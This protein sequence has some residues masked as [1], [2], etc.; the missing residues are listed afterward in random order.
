MTT[1]QPKPGCDLATTNPEL[2]KQA[3]DWDPTTATAVSHK[4]REWICESGHVWIATVVS[5]SQG[6]GCPYDAGK[7]ALAGY[8][9]LATTHPELAKQAHGRDLTTVM[10]KSMAGKKREWIC[11]LGHVW[12]ATVKDRLRGDGCPIHAGKQ[13]LEGYSDLATTHPEIA[14]QAHGWDPTVV[15][16]D[17]DESDEK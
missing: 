6:S 8:N 1:N 12:S 2:A 15:T 5:R 14:A 9:D 7:Q 13:V 3:H 11:K 10:A 4:K 17:G 16:R